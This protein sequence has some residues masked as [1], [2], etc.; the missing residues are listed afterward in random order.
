MTETPPFSLSR[1]SRIVIDRDGHFW[2][3]GQR[4]EH[5]RLAQALARWVAVDDATGRYI[6]RN[7]RE[8]CFVTV[9]DAPL[10]VRVFSP[11][12]Q[13]A[14]LTLSDGTNEALDPATLRIDPADVPYCNV[15]Q[16]TLPARFSR[17]AALALLESAQVLDGRVVVLVGGRKR[18]LPRVAADVAGRRP[19]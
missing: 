3:E 10:A 4:I 11:S 6:L 8:W 5:E 1:E 17:R 7:D 18:V 12:A 13:G 19:G 16:G 15:R 2:H 14:T 9:E